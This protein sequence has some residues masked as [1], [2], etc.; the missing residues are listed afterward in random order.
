M[1]VKQ[2][3]VFESLAGPTLTNCGYEPACNKP[4]ISKLEWFLYELQIKLGYF[5]KKYTLSS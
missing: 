5:Y 1:S 4:S 3:E 2:L